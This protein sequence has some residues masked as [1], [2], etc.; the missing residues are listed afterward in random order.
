MVLIIFYY[1]IKVTRH[2][3]GDCNLFGI[4]INI[5]TERIL[6]SLFVFIHNASSVSHK[7]MW[8]SSF[9]LVQVPYEQTHSIRVWTLPRDDTMSRRERARQTHPQSDG[10]SSMCGCTVGRPYGLLLFIFSARSSHRCQVAPAT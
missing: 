7:C 2:E 4:K 6:E 9:F 8:Y 3:F 1:S 5:I 10:R